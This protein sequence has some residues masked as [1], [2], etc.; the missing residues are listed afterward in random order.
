MFRIY[1]NNGSA[2]IGVE[3]P[4]FFLCFLILLFLSLPA[5]GATSR[6]TETI[7]NNQNPFPE[8]F[9]LN[10][11]DGE[12]ILI[13]RNNPLGPILEEIGQRSGVKIKIS[14]VLRSRKI[15]ISLKDIAIE[16]GIKKIAENSELIFGKYEEG[17]FYLS[18]L[19]FAA[20]TVKPSITKQE[21]GDIHVA[22][23]DVTPENQAENDAPDTIASQ[24][25][26]SE[27]N[28]LLNEMVIRFKQGISEQ[29]INQLLA[30]SNIKIKKY[31][32]ALKFH[33]LSLPEGMTYYDAMALFK[34]KKMIYQAEPEYLVPV[35]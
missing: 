22:L 13:T 3:I 18:E 15:T 14:P 29:A 26:N 17:S 23:K 28:I 5:K 6:S 30:D 34:S 21:K 8:K 24:N 20:D 16:E 2:S 9:F 33:I 1:R 25:S 19:P 35:K 12:I 10:I 4:S 11:N 32:A 27:N 31:I 7:Y